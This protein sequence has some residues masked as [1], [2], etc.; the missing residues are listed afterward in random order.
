MTV[1]AGFTN[2]GFVTLNTAGN[3]CGTGEGSATLNVTS[4]TLVNAVG[5]TI[6]A[7]N[8]NTN[9]ANFLNAALDN[10]GVLTVDYKLTLDKS[11]AQHSNSGTINLRNDNLTVAQAGISPLFATSGTINIAAGR[12]LTVSGGTFHYDAGTLSGTGTFVLSSTI[13]Q[14]TPDLSPPFSMELRSSTLNGPGD[15]TLV[16]PLLLVGGIVSSDVDLDN[17]SAI[18][19]IGS[20]SQIKG[21]F[22]NAVGASLLVSGSG[23]STGTL[24]VANGFTNEG[25]ITLNTTGNPQGSGDGSATLNVTSGTLV[26]ATGATVLA[27]KS[28]GQGTNSLNAALDNRG[29]LTADHRL[30]IDK[31]SAEHAN[32]GTIHLRNDNLT[33]SQS[34]ASSSFATSGTINIAAGRILTVSGGEFHY[35]AGILNG[36]GTFVLS[37]TIAQFTPDFSPPFSMELRSSTLNGPGDVTLVRSL[38]LVGGIVNSDVDLDN[39]SAIAVIGSTSQINGAFHN[40][41]G[42]SL[43]VSGSG[44]STGTL[45]VANGFTNEGTI[46]LNTAGNPFGS[47]DGSATLNVTSGTLVNATGATILATK[48]VGQGTNSLNAALDNRGTLTVDHRLIIDKPTAQ[49]HNSGIISVASGQTF[50]MDNGALTNLSAGTLTGGTYLIGGTFRFPNAAIATNAAKHRARRSS[51]SHRQS[52]RHQRPGQSHDECG[53]RQLHDHERPQPDNLRRFPQR[54]YPGRRRQQ[55]FHREWRLHAKRHGSATC[56]YRRQS[57]QRTVWSHDFLGQRC[58]GRVIER[59]PGQRLRAESGT[60][61]PHPGLHRPRR[62][63]RGHDR[64]VHRPS[65]DLRGRDQSQR[66]DPERHRRCDRPGGGAEPH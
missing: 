3:V 15:V 18:S 27:T 31:P 7:S 2:E 38:L 25:T 9:G 14:F 26:N 51:R 47:G 41:A 46:T 62:H 49:H 35:D 5:A 37:S 11:S 34:G 43:F 10:Q 60:K 45:T 66:R 56:R 64:A 44:G 58:P 24:T 6:L 55:H 53:G 61:L 59:Q 12:I 19:V 4:G 48:T 40:V 42:A 33:V 16:R 23:G 50:A 8:S 17:Q 21:A 28:V 20:T 39:Q 63:V 30:T 57:G 1:A 32:S 52:V 36:T 54:G 29:T 22:H 13:A 65:A